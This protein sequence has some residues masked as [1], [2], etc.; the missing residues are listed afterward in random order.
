M[1]EKVRDA[2]PVL[3]GSSKECCGCGACAA[4]CPMGA[5]DM[6]EGDRGFK[7]PAIRENVCVK[8]GLCKKVCGFQSPVDAVTTGPFYAATAAKDEPQ[9]ASG[10][11][12]ISL[13]RETVLAGGVAYGAAYD[14]EP[15]GLCVCH[16]RVSSIAEL[17]ALQGSKYVQ[18][19]AA[20]CYPQVERDLKDGLPVLFSGTPCQIAG[21]RGFLRRD[22]DNLATVDLVCHGVPSEKMFRGYV[23]S[24]EERFGKRI[25]DFRFRCKRDGWEHSLLLLLLLRPFEKQDEGADEEVLIPASDSPYYDMFLGLKTLRDSCYS[26]PF[27]GSARPADLTIGDFWG[28]E[29]RHPD[30][31]E[32]NGGAFSASKGIS[33]LLVNNERGVTALERLGGDLLLHPVDFDDIASGNDQLRASSALPSDRD[34]YL[35]AFSSDGWGAVEALWLRRTRLRRLK[36]RVGAVLP[37]GMR[38]FIKRVIHRG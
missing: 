5:I 19:D 10:G 28:V 18:S 3:F 6:V 36:R 30:L 25:V 2:V 7:V 21:L 14:V 26:C 13:A 17:A 1:S 11:V 24:L 15:D 27:A 31:L 8:C 29:A 4:R 23:S 16:R 37:Q 35:D 22:Y 38:N 12:F 20:A 33:C 32:E 34:E 9:S